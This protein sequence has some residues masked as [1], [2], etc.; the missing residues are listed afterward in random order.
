MKQNII[1]KFKKFEE[2]TDLL[3]T[4]LTSISDEKLSMKPE[5]NWSILQVLFHLNEA[6]TASLKYMKKKVQAGNKMG[7][8]GLL[9]RLQMKVTN[10]AL[11]SSLKWKAPSYISNPKAPETIEEVKNQWKKTRSEIMDFIEEYP[12]EYLDKLVYKHPMA[13]RQNLENAVD[14]FIFHQKHHLHQIRRIKKSL[15]IQ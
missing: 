14:S 5:G 2:D 11:G 3:L 9:N 4:K 6:E 15:D 8:I 10:V 7:E 13:G 12:E 1:D